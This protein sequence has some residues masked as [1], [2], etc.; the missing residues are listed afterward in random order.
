[1]MR[2]LGTLAMF[3][4]LTLFGGAPANAL[5]CSEPELIFALS[6]ASVTATDGTDES[7]PAEPVW[8]DARLDLFATEPQAVLVLSS[9]A[10]RFV[11]VTE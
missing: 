6:F 2:R 10:I 9:G 5:S 3:S 1:M 11:E 8:G 4:L 7:A